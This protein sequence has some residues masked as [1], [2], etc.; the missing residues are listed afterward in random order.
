GAATAGGSPTGALLCGG[1]GKRH[2]VQAQLEFRIGRP[3]KLNRAE[4]ERTHVRLPIAEALLRELGPSQREVLPFVTGR[5]RC[6]EVVAAAAALSRHRI[7]VLVYQH[8]PKT[9]LRALGPKADARV[10]RGIVGASSAGDFGQRETQSA[11]PTREITALDA[12]GSFAGV[13]TAR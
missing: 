9:R 6:L 7:A 11:S 5:E 1:R 4:L 10:G 3:L 12:R 8:R 13:A 2:V